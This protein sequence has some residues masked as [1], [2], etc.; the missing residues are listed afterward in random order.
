MLT[1]LEN[2]KRALSIFRTPHEFQSI[3]YPRPYS[4]LCRNIKLKGNDIY[5]KSFNVLDTKTWMSPTGS[6]SVILMRDVW[7][8]EISENFQD[9]TTHERP[10]KGKK[11]VVSAQL[12]W[13]M[14]LGKAR[15]LQT[16]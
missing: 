12:V 6:L 4:N 8:T 16:E 13:E 11:L 10:K 5:A 14:H 7:C 2:I 9:L 15:C 3:K 1:L